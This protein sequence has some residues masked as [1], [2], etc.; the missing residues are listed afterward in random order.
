MS[1][2][3]IVHL[4]DDTTAGGIMRMLDYIR[5]DPAMADLGQHEVVSVKRGQFSAPAV[6]A[7]V[8]VSH[9]SVC[10]RS[11]PMLIALRARYAGQTLV[12]IEHSYTE[13]FV[14]ARVR[15][16]ARFKTLLR[17]A[18]ALFDRVVAV[19]AAQG[20]WLSRRGLVSAPTLTVIPS[21]VDLVPFLALEPVYRRPR[22]IGAIG[23]FET[24][25]GFD[26]LIRAFRSAPDSE[27]RLRLIGDGSDR[28]HLHDLA[29]GDSRISFVGYSADPASVMAGLDAVAMPSR[30]EAYGLVALEARAA[31]RPLLVAPVDG[32]KDHIVAGA[33]VVPGGSLAGWQGALTQLACAGPALH[34]DVTRARAEARATM[35][36]TPVLWKNMLDG[37][38]R[39]ETSAVA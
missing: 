27:L 7:D 9:L 24:Q 12:H 35:A 38:V 37:A 31:G 15:N 3:T 1:R 34:I 17:T 16:Q 25:K 19:S 18:Y 2:K 22:V 13:A 30:W 33:K 29:K 32:L 23:R 39:P 5:T 11:L 21:C 28:A 26:T 6:S 36:D 20:E 14:A 8:I 10:W 4:V